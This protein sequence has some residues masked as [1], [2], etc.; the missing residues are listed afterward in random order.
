MWSPWPVR[1]AR[2]A[3]AATAI[4][5]ERARQPLARASAG[6]ERH[7]A[8]GAAPDEPAGFG[9]H[10]ELGGR[11]VGV[12]SGAAV[13]R[14][15]ADDEAGVRVEPRLRDRTPTRREALDH[16][17][18]AGDEV[19]DL[20]VAGTPDDRAHPVVQELEQRAADLGVDGR[21]A[22]RPGAPRI[23]ARRLDLHDVGAR[24]GEQPAAV[25]ARD[26]R[27]EIDDPERRQ[28]LLHGS[29]RRRRPEVRA[30]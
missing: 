25:R 3:A 14:D 16:D 19:L 15:R 29:G 26:P 27:A 7:A 28:T 9:L 18:G 23:A 30:A 24:V 20:G 8:H 17:V 2:R 6:L 4:A 22:R 12:G 11:P 5:G 21:A 13:R 10:D 1:R